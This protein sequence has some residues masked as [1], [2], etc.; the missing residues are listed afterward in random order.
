MKLI[1]L[2]QG[3]V[4]RVD[5]EDYEYL[6]QWKWRVNKSHGGFYAAR[7]AWAGLKKRKK[8]SMHRLLMNVDDPNTQ[9][10]HADR[11][12]LN[13]QKYNLRTCTNAENIKNRSSLKGSTSIYLGV[14]KS[15]RKKSYMTKRGYVT[16]IKFKWIAKIKTT[17]KEIT[18]GAW[19]YTPENEILAAKTYDEAAKI[20]HKEF[21]NLNFKD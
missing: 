8:I 21:A 17:S 3:Q 5:D 14:H 16:N 12:T 20:Y 7:T 15:T 19:D 10:D 1:Y 9:V 13:N 6:M 4:T 18:L 2:S 11:D